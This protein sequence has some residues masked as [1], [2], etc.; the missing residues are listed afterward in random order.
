VETNRRRAARTVLDT[1]FSCLTAWLAP[2]LVFTAEEAWQIRHP[3]EDGSVHLRTF[4]DVPAAWLDPAL[5]ERWERVRRVRR[6]VTGALEVERREK[7]IGSSLEAAPVVYLDAADRQALEGLDFA[8]LAITS[9]IELLTGAAPEGAF[10]LPDVPGVAVVPA[11]S[12]GR[13]CARCWRVL[14]EVRP[15]SGELCHRCEDALGRVAAE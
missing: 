1:L 7:R 14:P 8:E 6:V 13:K 11:L 3:S 5:A 10:A 15:Q 9:G 4:P 12:D 2:V